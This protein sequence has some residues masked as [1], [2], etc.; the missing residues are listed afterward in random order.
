MVVVHKHPSLPAKKGLGAAA[1]P[2]TA[3]MLRRGQHRTL[4][5]GWPRSGMIAAAPPSLR[6]IAQTSAA[7]QTTPAPGCPTSPYGAAPGQSMSPTALTCASAQFKEA[8]ASDKPD[9][10]HCLDC[11]PC[12]LA[13]QTREGAAC[14]SN[15]HCWDNTIGKHS[16]LMSM[17]R[18][19]PPA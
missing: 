9:G 16:E 7:R 19:H 11:F 3:L 5:S 8:I 2:P 1:A 18:G 10:V 12:S 6:Q 17:C 13:K 15:H 4:S 14:H